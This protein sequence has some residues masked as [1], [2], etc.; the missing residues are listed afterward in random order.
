VAHIVPYTPPS[1]PQE[2]PLK[3]SIVFEKDLIDPIRVKWDTLR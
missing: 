3:N 1:G 2:N